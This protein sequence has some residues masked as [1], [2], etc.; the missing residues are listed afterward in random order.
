MKLSL[1]VA[2][3]VAGAPLAVAATFAPGLVL[4]APKHS[5]PTGH[6]HFVAAPRV[7]AGRG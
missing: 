4:H 1:K 5:L 6:S 2:G 3:M 7:A